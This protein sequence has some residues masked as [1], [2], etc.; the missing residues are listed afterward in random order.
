[1][2]IGGRSARES[3]RISLGKVVD[4]PLAQR[5]DLSKA[6]PGMTM[7]GR[8]IRPPAQQSAPMKASA[9]NSGCG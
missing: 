6:T 8:A 4:T 3:T 9:A 2:R 1:M 5:L 7:S